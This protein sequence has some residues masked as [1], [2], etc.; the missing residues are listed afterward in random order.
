MIPC[1]IFKKKTYLSDETKWWNCKISLHW[2]WPWQLFATQTITFAQGGE[3]VSK[4]ARILHFVIQYQWAI[5]RHAAHS[6]LLFCSQLRRPRVAQTIPLAPSASSELYYVICY[7][8]GG[9]HRQPFLLG[10]NFEESKALIKQFF[11]SGKL[12][13]SSIYSTLVLVIYE[14]PFFIKC[15]RT[16]LIGSHKC[17]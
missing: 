2:S 10:R 14:S 1:L 3:C 5:L 17:L 12:F 4:A 9:Q 7:S 6:L 13:C 11:L 16:P 8:R 15:H